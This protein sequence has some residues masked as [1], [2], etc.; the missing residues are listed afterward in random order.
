MQTFI[1]HWDMERNAMLLDRQ[2]LGKQRLE[3]AQIAKACLGITN[4]WKNHPNVI[5]W[6]GYEPYLINEYMR[7][8]LLEWE[9]RGYKNDKMRE[10]FLA[11]SEM[12]EGRHIVKPFWVN[13]VIIEHR[14]LLLSKNFKFYRDKFY[15]ILNN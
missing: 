15:P 4:G 14:N 9:R 2:R 8:I 7:A 3:C 11:L 5:R 6:I 12:V 1:V 13:D 10:E